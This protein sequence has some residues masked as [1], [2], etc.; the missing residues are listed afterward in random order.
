MHRPPRT[1]VPLSGSWRFLQSDADRPERPDFN[2]TAWPLVE[3]P[4]SWPAGFRGLG[5]YRTS[6][7]L[8]KESVGKKI[9]LRFEAVNQVADVYLNGKLLG[10]HE[11]GYTAFVFD[12]SDA[13]VVPGRNVLAVKVTN[14]PNADLAP[15]SADFTFFGGIYR[16]VSLLMTSPI[17]ITPLDYGSSGVYLTQSEVSHSSAKLKVAAKIANASGN[18]ADLKVEAFVLDRTRRSVAKLTKSLHLDDKSL[19]TVSLDLKVANPR[20]WDGKLDPYL[21]SVVVRLLQIKEKKVKILD[22]VIQ[23]LGFRYFSANAANGFSL[24]GHPYRLEGVNMHQDWAGKGWALNSEDRRANV[25]ILR[26]LGANAVRLAHYP[27]AQETL[28]LLDRSGIVAWSEI[29]LVNKVT[30][31]DK[32][33][34][35]TKLQLTEMIHQYYN[36]P[37]ILFWGLYNEIDGDTIGLVDALNKLAHSL[38]PQRLTVAASNQAPEHPLNKIPDLLGVNRYDGWYFGKHSDSGKAMDAYKTAV[39]HPV[40]VSEY[41][42]GASILHHQDPP[43]QPPP[44]GHFHPEEYQNEF[45][46]VFY[47]NWQARPY[48]WGTFLWNVFDFSVV[49]RDEGDTKDRNDKGLMTYDRGTKKD[50]Y[51]FYKAQWNP[52]PVIHLASTRYADRKTNVVNVKVYS[53]LNEV[54]LFVNGAS[55]GTKLLPPNK[56]FLWPTV[57]L[58]S[59]KNEILAIGLS[60]EDGQEFH[61]QANWTAP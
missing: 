44:G 60:H 8:D 61:E 5:W 43:A 19:Q 49:G 7:S 47:A 9:F 33:A 42:A 1:E 59:G 52:E 13:L 18:A 58:K 28:Q 14:A 20:L 2:D 16:K 39:P 3:I 35:S 34:A 30:A 55:L 51:Y 48:L 22:E 50:S 31:S 41:G 24:N 12:L 26:D 45:H 53:N 32:F 15:V 23:P 11:G 25:R 36:H 29:P 17:Q 54:E 27:H 57:K 38:D 56:I 4:H 10:S 40:G 37:S 21:Y 46:E 6:F